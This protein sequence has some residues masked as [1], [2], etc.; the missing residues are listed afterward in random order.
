M[1]AFCINPSR[2]FPIG[3]FC[4]TPSLSFTPSLAD[5]DLRGTVVIFKWATLEPDH[6]WLPNL[7][8]LHAA[9]WVS[10]VPHPVHRKSHLVW[11]LEAA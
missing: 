6:P 8:D 5:P 2:A 1:K 3:T 10:G 7:V 9:G 11:R 4:R